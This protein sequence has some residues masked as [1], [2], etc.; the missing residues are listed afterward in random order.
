M[1]TK[2]LVSST[3]LI[4]FLAIASI[5]ITCY[6]QTEDRKVYTVCMG[7]LPTESVYTPMSHHQTILQDILEGSSVQDTLVHS[8]KRSFNGFSAKLT[9]KEVQKLSG[10]EGVVSVFPN[11]VYQ[12]QTTRSW[13]F[14]GLPEKWDL[15]RPESASFS[16]EGFGPPPKKWKGVCEGGDDFPCNNKLIGARFYGD[17]G[18]SARDT[19]GHGTHTSSTAAGSNARGAVPSARIAA[20][21]VCGSDGCQSDAIL[22]G[23]DD[24]I[25]DGVDIL[26]VSLGGTDPASFDT[27]PVAIGSFH[28]MKKGILT[29]HSA[30]NS[31]PEPQTVTSNAPWV[32]TVAASS[33]DRRVID[34]IVL[35]NGKTL[36]GLGVNGFKLKGTKFPLLYGEN[37]STTCETSSTTSCES[38]CL[39][40]DLVEGK[41]VICDSA[42][43]VTEAFTS[44]ATG[45]ILVSDP[46]LARFDVSSVYPLAASLI[47]T[48]NGDIVKSYFE[49]TRKP[50][51]TILPTESVKDS[52]APVVVSFSSRGPNSISPDIL[53]PD[54]SAPGVDILAAFSPVAN[55]S[56]VAGDTRSVKYNILSGTSM[57]CPHAT[58]AA[59]YIKTFHPDWSP[60]AIKSA[61][62]TTAFVMNNTKN[63]EAEFAYGSGQIDP[64]KAL[65]PGLVYDAHADDYVKYIC[66]LGFD[67]TKVKLITNSTCPRGSTASDYSRNLNYPSFGA[68]VEAGETINLKFTRTVTNVAKTEST[69]KVKVRSDDRIK[70]S[71]EPKVLSFES[72]NEKKK[73]V[74]TVTGDGLGSDE[75]ATA[76]L[77][78]SDEVHTVRSPIVVYSQSILY[79]G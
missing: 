17:V 66:G 32:L 1:A 36:Q 24:A 68:H 21:K 45:T 3:F 79:L 18:E 63:S 44:G 50:V 62:M 9:E 14:I 59:A 76:S 47:N 25:A 11:R 26:S 70:V 72:P 78:W 65:N 23:F 42:K 58:G 20:Y 12:L 60:S 69:Y 73:F 22:A 46:W 2:C 52:H 38:G 13:D 75:M 6:A 39:D 33:T 61:L 29:S 16:D 28:A 10:M 56:S 8:Y 67:S 19:Q 64:V 53:K 30:G 51:A 41:I 4:V 48:T 74:V 35:G 31:G 43:A 49:S 27:D 15:A 54:I 57:A 40:R 5:N 77:I 71:V 55:P 7:E 37:V 34:K